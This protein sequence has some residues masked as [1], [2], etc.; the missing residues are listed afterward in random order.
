M[1]LFDLLKS[2]TE[3]AADVKRRA[4]QER[5]EA[6]ARATAIVTPRSAAP[7]R[8]ATS[9]GLGRIAIDLPDDGAP[10]EI[11]AGLPTA[12]L[13][14]RAP[15]GPIVDHA[16]EPLLP[17]TLM[18][19][20][21]PEEEALVRAGLDDQ[22]LGIF[23]DERGGVL[24]HLFPTYAREDRLRY[25]LGNRLWTTLVV[26]S[27]PRDG[28]R[29]ALWGPFWTELP[30][31]VPEVTLS[32]HHWR[33]GVK[34]A[35]QELKAQI[36]KR[37]I[38]LNELRKESG[39][40]DARV[41]GLES[42]IE[43]MR[44]NLKQLVRQVETLFHLSAYIR[45]GADTAEQL[46]TKVTA[47]EELARGM[48]IS[49]MR[50]PGDQREAFI[51]SMPYAS[52]PAYYTSLRGSDAAAA[53]MPLISRPHI[54]RN[55]NGKNPVVL[56]GVHMANFTPVMMSPWNSNETI[57]ITTVLGRMGSGKSYWLRCHLG[58]LAM[59][60]VQTITIDPLGD[61]VRWHNENDGTVIEIAPGSDFHVNPFQRV[62]SE[63]DKSYEPLEEK[64]ERLMAMFRLILGDEYDAIASGLLEGGLKRFYETY[65]TEERL[66][67]DFL[68]VL[69]EFNASSAGA[70]DPDTVR[71]RGRL[72]DVL[73]LKCL[74]GA[75]APFFAFKT[76]INLDPKNPK[77]RKI[78]F[79]LKPSGDGELMV[80]A[81]YMAITM[82]ANIA[83]SSMDRKILLVDELHR[84]FR[85]QKMASGIEDF[86]RSFVRTHRHWNTALTFATQFVD[87]DDTNRGQEGILKG[88]GTWV[89]LRGTEKMLEQSAR[90]IGKDADLGLMTRVLK[91]SSAI[92]EEQRRSAKPMVI[93]R[94]GEPVP[95]FSIGL[96]FED[97]ED[98]KASG[99]RGV[100]SKLDEESGAI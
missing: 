29:P 98:D 54:E 48:G 81:S 32:M 86:L 74:D 71:S 41:V 1:G 40:M 12:R 68:E 31:I 56:Y 33:I 34:A 17:T 85:A 23:A 50:A 22:T 30:R 4:E 89:L 8:V 25:E 57:E 97:A 73:A 87:E 27:W 36:D 38:E 72:I 42:Q 35:T 7:S 6:I 21:G 59:V 10:R 37:E 14:V 63:I 77:A 90:L 76:N 64:I 61:F 13:V 2:P 75:Y 49:L 93:Y 94:A 69:K 70:L 82:A 24:R 66:M 99:V 15:S 80:F 9:D 53:L 39:P 3:R 46:Q 11:G 79:N 16:W 52:D 84:L 43:K 65:G 100:S 60:G 47:I 92:D 58:R 78:L 95:M 96:S 19:R 18:A 5:A 83:M 45:V 28:A 88:T 20:M 62:Y 44:A 26:R 91:I 51:S 67:G 55:L